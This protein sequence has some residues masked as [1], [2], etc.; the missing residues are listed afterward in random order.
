MCSEFG[1]Y[2]ATHSHVVTNPEWMYY[3]F[4]TACFVV[5]YLMCVLF[6]RLILDIID[7]MQ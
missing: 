4:I 7:R 2:L 3:A 1:E 6:T 5:P